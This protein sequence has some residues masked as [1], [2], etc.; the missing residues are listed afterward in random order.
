MAKSTSD[1][2]VRSGLSKLLGRF[3]HKIKTSAELAT[4]LGPRPRVQAVIMCHG[5]FDVVHPGHLRHLLYAKSRA[6]ILV[7]SITADVHIAKADFRPHVP[8]ALRALNLAALE[9]VDYVL[10]DPNPTPLETLAQRPRK[11]KTWSNPMA[12]K[13]SSRPVISS[14]H[15]PNLLPKRRQI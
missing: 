8:E 9:M 13:W 4:A 11:K 10:V 2:P 5:V 3:G 12:A 7:A 6:D 14:I 15:H 1:G